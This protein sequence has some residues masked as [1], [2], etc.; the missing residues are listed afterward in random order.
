MSV[1]PAAR[2]GGHAGILSENLLKI[3]LRAESRIFG[4]FRERVICVAELN[5]G[6]A[7]SLSQDII[8]QRHTGLLVKYTA[9]ML[10][11]V[12]QALCDVIQMNRLIDVNG[13]VVDN[14]A[15]EG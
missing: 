12:M 4:D 3:A 10:F 14:G 1:S 13:D 2:G 15:Y 7:Y 5:F 8:L 11:A 6:F 9:E